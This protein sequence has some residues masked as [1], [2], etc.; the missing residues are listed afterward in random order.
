MNWHKQT[1]QKR[2][3]FTQAVKHALNTPNNDAC[4]TLTTLKVSL[5]RGNCFDV[6]SAKI[7]KKL[8]H[9]YLNLGDKY[10][11]DALQFGFHSKEKVLIWFILR[12]VL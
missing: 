11:N 8:E 5:K 3:V 10:F 2:C 6:Q 4:I 12:F 7:A 9:V 1:A